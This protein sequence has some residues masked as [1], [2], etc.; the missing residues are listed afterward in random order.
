MQKTHSYTY[1][2]FFFKGLL[3]WLKDML[4]LPDAYFSP[5]CSVRE[6]NVGQSHV[7]NPYK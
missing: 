7:Q 1:K 5:H 3:L 2:I 6:D 4:P